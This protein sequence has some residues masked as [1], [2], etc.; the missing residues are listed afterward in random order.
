MVTEYVIEI[1]NRGRDGDCWQRWGA[2]DT[3]P[4]ARQCT[5]ALR[6]ALGERYEVRRRAVDTCQRTRR[7]K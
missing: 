3:E 4:E 2:T 7:A 6:A 1:R 5:K